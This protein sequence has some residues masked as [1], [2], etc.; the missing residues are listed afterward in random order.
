MELC[1]RE[2]LFCSLSMDPCAGGEECGERRGA[3][4]NHE[5]PAR[6]SPAPEMGLSHLGG[7][8]PWIYLPSPAHHGLFNFKARLSGLRIKHDAGVAGIGIFCVPAPSWVHHFPS[9]LPLLCV[10]ADFWGVYPTF[11]VGIWGCFPPLQ[12]RALSQVSRVTSAVTFTPLCPA[13]SL[14]KQ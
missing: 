7:L 3:T 5:I 1:I 9:A 8:T 12:L 2:R 4:L 6:Q 14:S 10:H 11:A 13:V